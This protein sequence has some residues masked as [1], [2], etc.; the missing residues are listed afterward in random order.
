MKNKSLFFLFLFASGSL[1]LGFSCDF[2]KAPESRPLP[3][4]GPICNT[5]ADCILVDSGDCCGCSAGGREIAIHKSQ[6]DSHYERLEERNCSQEEPIY[7][8]QVY[9]CGRYQARCQ[10]SQ[11]VALDPTVP[12]TSL[13]CNTD[14]D[15]VL[16]KDCIDANNGCCLRYIALHKSQEDIYYRN[17]TCITDRDRSDCHTASCDNY[18]T[19]C[20]NSQCVTLRY[21]SEG[22]DPVLIPNSSPSGQ[23]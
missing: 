14:A 13:T 19:Q 6:E 4:A 1:W 20:R 18:E 7:C 16:V 15:C 11:C 2:W 23:R 21:D 9:N 22:V 5:D 10:N 17:L 3:P 12:D 8:P